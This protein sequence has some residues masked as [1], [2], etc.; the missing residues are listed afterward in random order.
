MISYQYIHKALKA[1]EHDNRAILSME[2]YAKMFLESKIVSRE[3][4]PKDA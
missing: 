1:L 4:I 3:K 2:H